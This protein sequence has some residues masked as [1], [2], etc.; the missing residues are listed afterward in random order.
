[1]HGDIVIMDNPASHNAKIIRDTIKTADARLWFPPPYS[2]VL[3]PI[4]QI[5]AQIK[6]WMRIARKRKIE[7]AW[8]YVGK[9]VG[10]IS[11]E[12]CSNYIQNVGYDSV[13]NDRI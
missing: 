7:E 11:Q 1:M 4:E 10:S 2:P 3:N 9:L 12:K 13:K 6:H 8:R 5:F